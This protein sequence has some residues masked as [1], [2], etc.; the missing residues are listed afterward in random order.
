VDDDSSWSGDLEKLVGSAVVVFRA[1]ENAVVAQIEIPA[2]Q[3]LVAHA[4]DSV[5]ALV[6]DHA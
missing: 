4:D 1:I 2:I 3:A 5:L 6:A